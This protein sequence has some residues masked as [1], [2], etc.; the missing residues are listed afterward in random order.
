MFQNVLY[1]NDYNNTLASAYN[2][3]LMKKNEF[4]EP[5]LFDNKHLN[6]RLIGQLSG[7]SVASGGVRIVNKRPYINDVPLKRDDTKFLIPGTSNN[8]P[9]YNAQ[10]M[11]DIDNNNNIYEGG[12]VFK[13][14]GK[15]LKKVV[16]N[17]VVKKIISGSL[18]VGLPV[19]G[20]AVGSLVGQPVIGA[21]V[22]SMGR[23]VL[24]DATGYG[25]KSA[26]CMEKCKGGSVKTGGEK[27]GSRDKRAQLVKKIMKEKKLNLG[28]ASKY[29][30]EN[31]LM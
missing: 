10:E 8:Y 22:G 26:G 31:K 16:K 25:I 13:K 23:K 17:P 4:A 14:I 15:T 20:K 1:K 5:E 19:L 27:K 28:Q 11:R 24:K 18:D 7:G 21:T 12:N 6:K 3:L 2:N 29:I 9:M 30:K